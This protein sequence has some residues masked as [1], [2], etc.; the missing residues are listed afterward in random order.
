M[1]TIGSLITF[2]IIVVVI[3]IIDTIL[4]EVSFFGALQLLFVFNIGTGKMYLLFAAIFGLFSAIIVDFRR[5]KT[6]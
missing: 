2:T 1:V 3:T 6:D 4:Y 5:Q